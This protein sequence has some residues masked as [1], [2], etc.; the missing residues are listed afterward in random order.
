MTQARRIEFD[1]E[2]QR[3]L[4]RLAQR[5]NDAKHPDATRR[6]SD[7]FTDVELDYIGLLGED[8]PAQYLGLEID[9]AIHGH[10]DGG[11]D[12]VLPDGR[13]AACKFNH[14]YAGFLLF[15]QRAGDVPRSALNDFSADVAILTFGSCRPPACV[16]LEPGISVFIAG[17]IGRTEF[18]DRY[19]AKDWGLGGRYCMKP[20]ALHPIDELL[21][22]TAAQLWEAVGP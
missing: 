11:T 17:W 10:G 5:R 3:E 7:V 16:C 1:V 12:L 18:L 19:F 22:P 8:A 9:T 6:R 14:R 4:Y 20:S 15:E 13:R 21:E 2:R